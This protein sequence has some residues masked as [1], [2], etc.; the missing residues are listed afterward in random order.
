MVLP[1]ND[2]VRNDWIIV[3][4]SFIRLSNSSAGPARSKALPLYYVSRGFGPCLDAGQM[5]L[6]APVF[7]LYVFHFIVDFTCVNVEYIST[8]GNV[9]LIN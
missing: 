3:I 9:V 6:M 5:G 4:D 7:L 2:C 1:S 8:T